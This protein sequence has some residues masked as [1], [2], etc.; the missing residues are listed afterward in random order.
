LAPAELPEMSSDKIASSDFIDVTTKL[1]GSLLHIE[2]TQLK[3]MDNFCQNPPHFELVERVGKYGHC[4][5]YEEK[6]KMSKEGRKR[7]KDLADTST[8]KS[9]TE[10]DDMD[11]KKS[12]LKTKILY[13]LAHYHKYGYDFKY[14]IICGGLILLLSLS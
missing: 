11:N 3:R 9:Q 12:E 13:L 2:R 7:L 4:C 1:F 8:E 5:G 6:L 14:K 10:T